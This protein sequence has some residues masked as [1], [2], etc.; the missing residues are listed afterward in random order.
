MGVHR[1]NTS[2]KQRLAGAAAAAISLVSAPLLVAQ[3]VNAEAPARAA[4]LCRA[5]M[6]DATPKDYTYDSVFVTTG[7][8]AAIRTVA[9]YKTTDTTKR[10][11]ANGTGHGSTRYYISSATP[12]YRV[13]VDVYV[14]KPGLS[15]HCRT[16]F[17]PHR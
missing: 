4:M 6:G 8:Y 9:H 1:M 11:K 15:G 17:V 12:G 16:S 2:V 14:S 3:P 13:Y 5:H 7:R 10:A